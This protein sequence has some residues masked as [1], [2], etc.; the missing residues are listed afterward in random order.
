M[1]RDLP[2]P[3]G[4]ID[5]TTVTTLYAFGASWENTACP[6][7]KRIPTNNENFMIFCF[8]S[9]NKVQGTVINNSIFM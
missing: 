9:A 3:P 7:S 6:A 2:I 4:T 5:S 8:M 1:I